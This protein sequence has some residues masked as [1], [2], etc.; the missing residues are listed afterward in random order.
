MHIVFSG[1]KPLT[2]WILC[3]MSVAIR[4]PGGPGNAQPKDNKTSF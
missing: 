3:A 2:I 1:K 4:S